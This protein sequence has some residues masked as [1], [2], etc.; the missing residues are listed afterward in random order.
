MSYQGVSPPGPIPHIG[1][2][3]A[4]MRGAKQK[5]GRDEVVEAESP[6]CVRSSTVT[7]IAIDHRQILQPS[8]LTV[9]MHQLPCRHVRCEIAFTYGAE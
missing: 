2:G 5:R 4:C 1:C 6:V 8:I 9:R 3:I 7:R